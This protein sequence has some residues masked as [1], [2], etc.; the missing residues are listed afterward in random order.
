MAGYREAALEGRRARW[1]QTARLPAFDWRIP[2]G[3]AVTAA[4]VLL[5]LTGV[6][7]GT[8]IVLPIHYGDGQAA[9]LGKPENQTDIF[10]FGRTEQPCGQAMTFKAMDASIQPAF[11]QTTVVRVAPSRSSRRYFTARV[12]VAT[13]AVRLIPQQV[14]PGA[15]F[16][17]GFI[18]TGAPAMTVLAR[19]I[20]GGQ[21]T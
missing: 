20:S 12:D 16:K 17:P 9:V 19:L 2:G 14:C 8:Q 5:L 10:F 7:V 6:S 1:D 13:D 18:E 21:G 4:A 3:M 15:S 11:A